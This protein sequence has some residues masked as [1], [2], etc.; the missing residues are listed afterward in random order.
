MPGPISRPLIA[1]VEDDAA[2]LNSLEFALQAEGYA[3]CAFGRATEALLSAEVMRA[4][5]LVLD[6][7]MP[8]LT[9]VAL[10]GQLRRRGLERPAIIIA[11]NPHA[12]CLQEA[13][14]AGALV[15]EKPLTG[16]H[17]L[18]QIRRALT[19]SA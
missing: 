18:D 14:E 7:G 4:D 5:C 16:E 10:L 19:G 13:A 2:V 17:L 6:Y 8:D 1:V 15:I 3:V 12:R 11:S 9:G